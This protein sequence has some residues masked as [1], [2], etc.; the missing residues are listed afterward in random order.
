MN[1]FLGFGLALCVGLSAT[2][3]AAQAQPVKAGAGSYFVGPKGS[4]KGLPAAPFRT[5]AMLKQA[6]PTS[7]WYSTLIF[8]PK[9]DPI[10]VQ[11]MTVR[12]TSAGFELVLPSKEV[13][14][15]ER[16]DTEVGYPHRDPL[17]QY[18]DDDCLEIFLDEDFSGG[19][20]IRAHLA[21]ETGAEG[22]FRRCR[23]CG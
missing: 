17:V 9:P 1:R 21:V 16:R 18:W 8:N 6:A 4:D 3:P 7:Q 23:G 11:P 10:F 19:D 2:L 5:E 22:E 13:V 12:T 15:T 14:A 20:V